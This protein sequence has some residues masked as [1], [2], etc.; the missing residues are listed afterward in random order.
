MRFA[1]RVPACGRLPLFAY[2]IMLKEKNPYILRYFVHI[3]IIIIIGCACL[4][5][6]CRR[7]TPQSVTLRLD[8][9]QELM[10]AH[11]DSALSI[12]EATDTASLLDPA[13]RARYALL[14]A[15]A[16]DKNLI[17]TSD[18]NI[19]RPAIDYYS[20]HGNTD[21]KINTLFYQGRIYMNRGDDD[22]AMNCFLKAADEIPLASDS[23]AIARVLIAK[24]HM[25]CKRLEFEKYM[26]E[27]LKAADIYRKLDQPRLEA[28]SVTRALSGANLTND[29]SCANMILS[30]N[31]PLIAEYFDSM[32]ALPDELL[33]SYILFRP[34]SALRSL[35]P[36][37]DS[38]PEKTVDTYI[39]S[40]L[41]LQR[42]GLYDR[43]IRTLPPLDSISCLEDSTRMIAI[44]SELLEKNGDYKEALADYHLYIDCFERYMN[45]L[46][47]NDLLFSQK[48]Y[49]LELN[50]QKALAKSETSRRN[51]MIC[52]LIAIIIAGII[53]ALLYI[54]NLKYRNLAL[55]LKFE[56]EKLEEIKTETDSIR[57]LVS[58]RLSA[59][60]GLLAS[61]ISND[62]KYAHVYHKM[63]KTLHDDKR[64]FMKS[65]RNELKI[66]HPEFMAY[67]YEHNLDS[68]ELDC[69]TLLAIGLQIKD[70]RLFMNIKGIYNLT[71]R[72]RTKLNLDA[73]VSDLAAYI[74]N[75]FHT[76]EFKDIKRAYHRDL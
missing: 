50:A 54:K 76:P 47:N 19:L 18:L 3:L 65:L 52:L 24:G 45:Q 75:I 38:L 12:L 39:C 37:I 56:Q 58:Q 22:A 29:T 14:H 69:I 70:I 53:A 35:L 27:N 1:H 4:T 21:Q 17:C 60:N 9:A 16:L 42:M 64:A 8:R 11:P 7:L 2:Q 5:S 34:D 68:R 10:E 31:A 57:A 36:R 40:A 67:L 48:K 59:L 23:L 43:A 63:L 73:D 44:R 61:E 51:L 26:E 49:E 72:I 41:A 66:S 20:S 62:E 71:A 32:P 6:G 55:T 28:E 25:H 13:S 74:H 46:C 33:N 15:M 30:C